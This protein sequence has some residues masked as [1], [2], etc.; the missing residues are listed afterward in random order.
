M[1]YNSLLSISLVILF[2]I[3]IFSVIISNDEPLEANL[4]S[5]SNDTIQYTDNH[6]ILEIGPSS[7][8]AILELPGGHNV[9]HKLPL[10]VAL[11]GYTSSGLGVSG[12]FDLI[13]SVHE[14]GHLLL[15]PD[16]TISATGQ[17]FWN[18]TDACCNIWGQEVDDVSWLTSLINEAITY[19]GADPEGII[20]VGYSNGGFMAHRMACERG[21]MLRSI[22][23]LAGATHYDFNDCPNTGYPNVLQIHGT[24]DSVIFYDGGAILGDN[25]PAASQTV[26]SWANRSGCDLTYTEIN[27]L[28]LISPRGVN[29]TNEYEHLNC[30]SGNRVSLWEIP[31]GS[32]YP[33]LSSSSDDDFPST[34]LDWGLTGYFPD[35]DADG[36]RDNLDA[37]P[38]NPL[39]TSD[40]DGDGVGDNT[41]QFPLNPNEII[42]SDGDGV[43]DNSDIFPENPH[44]QI[45][46]DGDGVGDNSDIFPNDSTE[47]QDTDSDGI[48][49]N[50][51]VFPNDSTE[52]LDTDR[53]GV[54]DNADQFPLNPNE[55]IDSDGD[56]VGDN[57]DIFPENPYEQIDSDGDGIGDNSDVFPQDSNETLDSDADGSGDNS[58]IFPYNPY[59]QID[60]DADGVGDNSDVFPYN[61]NETLDSDGDGVGDNLDIFPYNSNETL[62]SDGDGIGDNSDI[63]P[64]DS[65]EWLDTDADGIG[66]NSDVF[67]FD[68]SEYLDFDN[69]GIGDNSDIFPDDPNEHVD[70][71][72]DGVGDNSDAFP[73]DSSEDSD[74]DGDGVGD[75]SDFYP[76]DSTR[77]IE[78][79]S[80]PLNII[81]I[82]LFLSL[83]LY[84][85]TNSPS[86]NNLSNDLLFTEEE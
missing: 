61:P 43:G 21:D 71:D 49:D 22:I 47:W 79:K 37:F 46:S 33:Q 17:R 83:I 76:G 63:F 11:H 32:H 13:D 34:I 75:N 16:G 30:S 70:S 82:M 52:W 24:S 26:F 48:G 1:K 20:I 74:T 6:T 14:N 78:E 68:S 50:S 40:S 51:D 2:L 12:F 38:N 77:S 54:G 41:D 31:N 73:D 18:A 8:K 86:N 57:S 67:P 66:D 85:T 56:G 35:S 19:H 15:R 23:S 80:N 36:V 4:N 69:D 58:D 59:E 10:V 42:D 9:S 29:D 3:S 65:T 5:I 27:Q 45:D 64:N 72:G 39:E 44:E 60:S 53:D 84:I 55:I 62:D 81:F 7:R 28:D 25:Y